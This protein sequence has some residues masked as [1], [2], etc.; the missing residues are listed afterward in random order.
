M[1]P[2]PLNTL[3][4]KPKKLLSIKCSV[5]KLQNAMSFTEI[6]SKWN[7]YVQ[8]PTTWNTHTHRQPLSLEAWIKSNEEYKSDLCVIEK[9]LSPP[10]CQSKDK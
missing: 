6:R 10:L 3:W 4:H 1:L 7:A 5:I 9:W 8:Q 2:S